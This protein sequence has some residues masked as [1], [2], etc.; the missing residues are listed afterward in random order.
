MKS[1]EMERIYWALRKF[2][3]EPVETGNE[4]LPIGYKLT[5]EEY[6][7]LEPFFNMRVET[8]YIINSAL[9]V[10]DETSAAPVRLELENGDIYVN[11]P[12]EIKEA[13]ILCFTHIMWNYKKLSHAVLYQD[14]KC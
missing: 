13:W 12:K 14:V 6:K 3:G 11:A 2:D 10:D 4:L 5:R 8:K 7:L 1:D 9:E